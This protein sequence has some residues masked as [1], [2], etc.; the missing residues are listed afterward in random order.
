[1]KK[2]FLWILTL[3][4]VGSGSFALGRLYLQQHSKSSDPVISDWDNKFCPAQFPCQKHSFVLL[5]CG[6][7][8][9]AYLEKT[10]RSVFSQ[11]YDN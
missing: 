2:A 4:T 8:N 11:V 9:G 1:M 10:L 7:N 5:I 6:F 3:V